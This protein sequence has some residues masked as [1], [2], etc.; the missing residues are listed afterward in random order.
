MTRDT[1]R[2]FLGR[3][4][5]CQ[6]CPWCGLVLSPK[7]C[8]RRTRWL[9]P[10]WP[11]HCPRQ[12]KTCSIKSHD[13]WMQAH[14]WLMIANAKLTGICFIVSLCSTMQ[15]H[16]YGFKQNNKG[17]VLLLQILYQATNAPPRTRMRS[18]H[19]S[20]GPWASTCSRPLTSA[21]VSGPGPV[22]RAQTWRWAAGASLW[23]PSSWTLGTPWGWGPCS[24]IAPAPRCTLAG[25]CCRTEPSRPPAMTSRAPGCDIRW[26]QLHQPRQTGPRTRR[27]SSKA[28][29][30]VC[31]SVLTRSL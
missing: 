22:A 3:T 1:H 13:R 14:V 24:G 8:T 7:S 30:P 10:A 6:W 31:R 9:E 20:W 11:P 28:K 4:S 12:R 5:G 29:W 15:A 27:I 25:W 18:G 23:A 21:P 16:A 26:G 19:C 17:Q 2:T